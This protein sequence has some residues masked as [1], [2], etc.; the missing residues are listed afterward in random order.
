MELVKQHGLATHPAIAPHVA[1][2]T[3]LQQAHQ[4]MSGKAAAAHTSQIF[5]ANNNLKK[6]LGSTGFVPPI[7]IAARQLVMKAEALP[8][9]QWTQAVSW[10]S[11]ATQD[12][13]TGAALVKGTPQASTY[14][15]EGDA[16]SAKVQQIRKT[17]TTAAHAITHAAAQPTK[18]A[19]S[20]FFTTSH[21]ANFKKPEPEPELSAEQ[22][23]E[24]IAVQHQQLPAPIIEP[25][26]V[27]VT[28]LMALV[29]LHGHDKHADIK[30][31][32]EKLEKLYAE[33]SGMTGK[34]AA[35]HTSKIYQANVTL[36]KLLVK[37]AGF[38]EK[39][40]PQKKGAQAPSKIEK[41]APAVA[42]PVPTNQTAL[43]KKW[44]D[45]YDP[46]KD[47]ESASWTSAPKGYTFDPH[48]RKWLPP[49]P[50]VLEGPQT[51]HG[52]QMTEAAFKALR[53]AHTAGISSSHV[54]SSIMAYSGSAY[55]SI[56]GALRSHTGPGMQSLTSEV[57]QHVAN[58]D[59]AIAHSPAPHDL[60]LH[61]GISGSKVE[62]LYGSLK[63][64]DMITDQGYSSTSSQ[65]G[66][67]FGGSVE[68]KIHVPKG[69][70]AMAI[71]SNHPNEQEI[72]L[73][74]STKTRVVRV[75]TV[76]GNYGGQKR[77]VHMEVVP[78]QAHPVTPPKHVPGAA[79]TADADKLSVAA[80]FLQEKA[81]HADLQTGPDPK[82]ENQKNF[83]LAMQAH[84][85]AAAAY[86]NIGKNAEA[87]KHLDKVKFIKEEYF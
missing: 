20:A 36:K 31:A 29:K 11:A 56:N 16:A 15:K 25:G 83:N 33:H 85:K 82:A 7:V 47:P 12:F 72:L 77:V 46:K 27:K 32:V 38:D 48:Q 60:L 63:P 79:L 74:R 10:L 57:A 5:Q 75:E 66:S 30:A 41:A 49:K 6:A 71:P 81:E 22:K 4:G 76:P 28:G 14:T 18:P 65:P 67:A 9:S 87:Q 3:Q 21:T 45:K 24:E 44:G 59:H 58:I 19:L 64:G 54:Q 37:H 86:S 73:P 42:K 40:L 43:Q 1:K 34:A 39:I 70:P 23:K 13:H 78:N 52:Q 69:H 80:D 61:R 2:L 68:L 17:Q 50:I 8:A 55:S 35:T 26:G 84:L 62:E 51:V 53:K